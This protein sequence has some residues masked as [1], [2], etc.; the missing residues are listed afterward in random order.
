MNTKIKIGVI[1]VNNKNE[2]LLLKEKVKKNELPL[3]NIVKGT[4]GDN[5]DETIQEAAKRECLEEASVMVDLIGATGCFVTGKPDNLKIQFN[6]IA[7]ILSGKPKIASKEEQQSRDEDIREIKWFNKDK[8]SQM[9]KEKFISEKIFVV[10]SDWLKGENYPL[11][12]LKQ[13]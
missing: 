4:Y 2:I 5:G 3:W 8:L 13:F 6:F 9:P 12:I 1:I 7:R 10:V 11:S